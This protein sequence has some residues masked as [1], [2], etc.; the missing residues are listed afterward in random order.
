MDISKLHSKHLDLFNEPKR[1]NISKQ[2]VQKLL[3][4]IE[5]PE[6]LS[7]NFDFENR[8]V[9]LLN[10]RSQQTILLYASQPQGRHIAFG[11]QLQD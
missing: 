5:V 2:G 3:G 10:K 7:V 1:N 6:H 11:K 8:V 4:N 9:I